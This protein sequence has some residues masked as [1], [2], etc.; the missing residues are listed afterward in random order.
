MS[1][2]YFWSDLHL[3]HDNIIKFRK[4]FSTPE[5]H[6]ETIFDRLATTIGKRDKITLLG[7]ICFTRYW[8]DKIRSI[9]CISKVLILGNHD[10]ERDISCLEYCSVFDQV[11]GL[12][13]TKG[14]WLSHAPI[15]PNE[16]RGCRNIHGHVHDNPIDD[17]RYISVCVESHPFPVDITKL[18]EV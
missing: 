14:F 9:K 10:T 13:K 3:G 12:L 18:K 8:L 6:H 11:H 5:E 16:L 2:S 4:Q 15:H 1:K 7:D 17:D